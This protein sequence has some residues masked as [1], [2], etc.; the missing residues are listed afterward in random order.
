MSCLFPGASSLREYWTNVRDGFDAITDVPESHWS[1]GDYFNADPKAPDMTYGRRGGF[2]D[3]VDFDPMGF[4][5]SPRDLEATDST[6]LLG[7]HVAREALRDAGYGADG[8]EFDRERTSVIL[9]VSGTLPLVIPLGARLGHPIWRQALAESGVDPETSEDVITR[10]ASGYVPWQEN[11]FPGLLANVVAGRIANRLD[12]RGT[13]CIVDAACASSLSAIHLASLEL[14]AGRA[15]MVLSGGLD[16]FNDIFMYM[17]FSKTPALSTSGNAQPFNQDADGT[18]LG[19]GVGVVA[20]KRLA[21]AERDGDR[22]YAVIKGLGSSSD[23]KG[24]AVYAPSPEGQARALRAA[25]HNAGVTPDTVG[26]LEAHGTGTIVGDATEARGLTSVYEDTGREGS[27]CA[28]GSVKSMIGHT[29][30]AAGAAGLIKAVM[31]LHHKVLPPTIKVEA[32]NEAVAPGE[33]PFYVNTEKRPWLREN[34]HPRR[35]GVSAF[36]FGG[37]NFHCVVEEY[38]SQATHVD[39][40]GRDQILAF[41]TESREALV[42]KLKDFDAGS[43]WAEFRGQAAETREAFDASHEFR[44][45]MVVQRDGKSP[46]DLITLALARLKEAQSTWSL[47]QGVFFGSGSAKG[48]WAACF[49]GQGAQ[50]VGM[51]R[52]LMC[53]FPDAADTLGAATEATPGLAD[54]LY[55]HPAFDDDSRAEQEAGLRATQTAQPALGAVSLGAFRVLE[56]FGITPDATCGHSYGELV[57]L[58]AAGRIQPEELYELSRLRGELMARGECDHGSML[59]VS[60]ESERVQALIQRHDLDLVVANH[61][62]PRQVVLSGVTNEIDRATEIL[63]HEGLQ[64]KKLPVSAAFHSGLVA[65]AAAPFAETLKG[66]E[67]T[68]SAVPVYANT[69]GTSYPKAPAAARSVLAKQMVSR[70]DFVQCVK[71]MFDN[72]I[73]TFVEVGPGRRLSG[74]IGEILAGEEI[75]VVAVDASSGQRPGLVDLA[76]M[77]AQFAAAGH[78][79]ALDQW[80]EGALEAWRLEAAQEKPALTVKISGANHV[81]ERPKRPPRAAAPIPVASATAPAASAPSTSEPAAT[82]TSDPQVLAEAIRASQASLAALV[83]LQEQTAEVHRQFLESQE[84]TIQAIIQHQGL[85]V[86]GEAV[87]AAA[88]EIPTALLAPLAV[89][90]PLQTQIPSAPA[91]MPAGAP[92]SL[93]PGLP[94][95]L[96][97]GAAAE[98]PV[99]ALG[100]APVDVIPGVAAALLSVVSEKTGYPEEMLDLSMGLD[101]DLGIDSIKRVEILSALQERLP[102]TPVITPEHLGEIQTLGQIVDFLGG[103]TEPSTNDG[104]TPDGD[105]AAAVL[106]KAD[107]PAVDSAAPKPN[108]AAD[109]TTN[110]VVAEVVLG[111]VAEKTGYPVD[112]LDVSMNLDADL[113]IDSIKR[114]EILSALQEVLP[115]APVVPPDQLGELRTL[116]QIVGLLSSEPESALAHSS[117]EP[118]EQV[119]ESAAD[120]IRSRSDDIE[121]FVPTLRPVHGAGDPIG[122]PPGSKI[123]VTKSG[124]VLSGQIVEELSAQGFAAEEIELG[125]D[126]H[127]PPDEL[128][129]LIVVVPPQVTDEDILFGFGRMRAMAPVLRRAALQGGALLCS[130]TAL[131]GGF[132]LDAPPPEDVDPTGGAWGG[133]LKTAAAEWTDVNCR[134]IDVDLSRRGLAAEIVRHALSQGPVE[135]GLGPDGPQ[136]VVLEPRSVQPAEGSF[137]GS[138]DTVLITGGARGVTAEVAVAMAEAGQPRLILMGRSPE[139]EKEPDWL[140]GLN[141]EAEIKRAILTHAGPSITLHEVQAEFNRIRAG[142]EIRRTIERISQAGSEVA[143]RSADVRDADAVHQ[144][145]APLIEE[146]GPVTGLVHGAGVLADRNIEDKSDDDFAQVYGTKVGGLR[147]VLNAIGESSL[148]AMV[149]FSSSTARFGRRGQVDYAAANEV[150]NKVA[151]VEAAQRDGCRVVSVNWGPWDG[152]MVTSGLRAV[153]AD[154]GIEMIGMRSGAAY[155]LDEIAAPDGPAEVLVLGSG[156]QIPQVGSPPVPGRNGAQASANVARTGIAPTGRNGAGTAGNGTAELPAELPVEL[157]TE[158]PTVFERTISTDTHEFMASHVLDGRAVLPAAMT[159]EWLAHGALHGNPGVRFVGVDDLRVFKGVL[160]HPNESTRVRICADKAQKRGNEF[161]VVTELCSDGIDNRR[162]LHARA[163]VVLAAKPPEAGTAKTSSDLPALDQSIETIYAETLFHGPKM[164]GLLAIES[165]GD[166]GLVARCRVAPP[167]RDWMEEPVRSRWI[168]DPLA[169]DSGLQAMI[170]WTSDRVGKLSLPSRFAR[171]RQFVPSFPK[172]GARIVIDVHERTNGKVVSDIDWIGDDGS[173]L[174]RLEGYESVVDSSLGKAFRHNR[175]DESAPTRA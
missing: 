6:Q 68:K 166:A 95:G 114:V 123:W 80:D 153:F 97:A 39:W 88:V 63:S 101:A 2:L 86:P 139:P 85:A 168:A 136:T 104:N 37:S 116:S 170:V 157:P 41:S 135:I 100:D 96:P 171:Y 158:L 103:S 169:L 69:T 55:P 150:L 145:L 107:G 82:V 43:A 75:T 72:G 45:L 24:Q 120:E 161:L 102:D 156:S 11:S 111:V 17:C 18:I 15:D 53:R 64:T 109:S 23:G 3:A 143:Y 8:R 173:L 141:S 133:M 132:A 159:L 138:D 115:D 77:L 51:L 131:G 128:A 57:A 54:I 26:L 14:E 76:R 94:T 16:T 89:Q 34:D 29:K 106:A 71:A 58:C 1:V 99:A 78:A 42:S 30:A 121:R 175:L 83:R 35:A 70:V 148:K 151:Q 92:A 7:M 165:C 40:D 46:V 127:D 147:S 12:L 61:N 31:A 10:I 146:Y 155:L 117:P 152:G 105:V 59:A 108:G 126:G 119:A 38:E 113:G 56:Q 154:E 129:G 122:L 172:G 67:L 87:A 49:P 118:A 19:E 9:G 25:Y 33:T 74:L 81:T 163:V 84:R 125:D 21:D 73:R 27:W 149:L 4:G 130:V 60:A 164:R 110:G 20:L 160:V 112:M 79:V 137:P 32:P 52:E 98:A 5:I 28:L 22:V 174:A 162:V 140:I 167:P 13:N 91:D 62:A 124:D 65:D 44:L 66:V 93:P 48:G 142:R 90:I 144:T 50:Y 134:T 36:G 47:P